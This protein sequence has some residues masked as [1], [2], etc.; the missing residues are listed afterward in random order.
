MASSTEW[1]LPLDLPDVNIL[2]E[3]PTFDRVVR[4]FLLSLSLTL[5]AS[6]ADNDATIRHPLLS[7]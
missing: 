7:I 4:S 5:S 3:E 2:S 6:V 1:L